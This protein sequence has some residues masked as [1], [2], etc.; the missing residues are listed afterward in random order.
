M[1]GV[2][3]LR[4]PAGAVV[5]Q[6]Q[7]AGSRFYGCRGV[8]WDVRA[9]KTDRWRPV[10]TALSIGRL[11]TFNWSGI[12]F[13]TVEFPHFRDKDRN[14]VDIVIENRRGRQGRTVWR[15]AVRRADLDALAMRRQVLVS[16]TWGEN[17]AG[18]QI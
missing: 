9:S 18:C 8:G 15:T 10:R 7:A 5:W 14:E 2:Q 1:E 12:D 6:R 13:Q 3:G 17:G 16:V 11:L 4:S